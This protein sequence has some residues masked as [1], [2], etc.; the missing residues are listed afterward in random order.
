MEESED[1]ERRGLNDMKRGATSVKDARDQQ[2]V[3]AKR[4]IGGPG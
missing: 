4:E 1:A 3:R 2:G